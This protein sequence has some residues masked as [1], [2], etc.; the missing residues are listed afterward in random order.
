MP[1][2][3]P[4]FEAEQVELRNLVLKSRRFVECCKGGYGNLDIRRFFGV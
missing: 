4:F 3:P 1:L 2:K